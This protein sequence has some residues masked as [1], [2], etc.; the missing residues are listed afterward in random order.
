MKIPTLT[1]LV[2]LAGVSPAFAKT[3]NSRIVRD[4][5]I[6]AAAGAIIGGH[7]GDR[8]AEGAV[9][10]G[11][12]G[13]VVGATIDQPRSHRTVVVTRPAP[14]VVVKHPH[15]PVRRVVACAPAPKVVVVAGSCG[16]G[17]HHHH[18][19]GHRGCH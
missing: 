10:G 8:W 15:R 9:I 16:H 13:A 14:V 7:Q 11:A 17:R 5:V 3:D 1:L 19:H 12:V 4:A 2:L 6:G 18:H